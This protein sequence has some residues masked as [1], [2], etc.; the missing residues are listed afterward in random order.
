MDPE[1]VVSHAD[2]AIQDDLR[3]LLADFETPEPDEDEVEAV[4]DIA[5]DDLEVI[6]ADLERADIYAEAESDGEIIDD[7][8]VE[9]EK[10]AKAKRERK[11]RAV[12]EK[13]KSPKI[14]R[15]L[16]ALPPEAFKRFKDDKVN[17]ALRDR[18]IATRPAQKKIAEK[19][20]Q[21]LSALHAGRLPSVYVVECFKELFDRKAVKSTELTARMTGPMGLNSGTASSQVGQI[22]TLFPVL[23]IAT[24]TGAEL[25]YRDD[26][27]I[28]EK[29][30]HLI[31]G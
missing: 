10:P 24:R 3:S 1:H 21:T 13:A 22:M 27:V 12:S 14:E 20:D 16:S 17:E 19:F 28:G 25:T 2:L 23:G 6:Q 9:S 15:D 30:R 18:V 29:L 26:S 4:E 11:A 7:M 5:E 8:A 31:E